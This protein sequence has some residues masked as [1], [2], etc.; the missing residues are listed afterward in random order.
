LVKYYTSM[1]KKAP[2]QSHVEEPALA[3]TP[4]KATVIPIVPVLLTTASKK[5]ESQ[6]TTFEKIDMIK[7]GILKKDLENLK[8]VAD[9]DYDQLAQ[10]LSVTRATLINKKK[11]EKFSQSL[12]EKIVVLADIYSYGYEVFE[13]EEKFNSWIFRPSRA[14]GGK[15]PF[16][17]MD[18]Q[19]GREEVKNLIGR[20]A[21][22][23]YS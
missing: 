12:S 4:K 14:L 16:D 13:D 19:Y 23:V 21:Y 7:E 6:M 3:Y 18:N 20:I 10:A 17:L 15:A 2:K 5:P 11:N 8:E 22:G 9:L 1:D